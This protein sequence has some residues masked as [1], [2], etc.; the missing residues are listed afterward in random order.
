MNFMSEV[1]NGNSD[2]TQPKAEETQEKPKGEESAPPA[3]KTEEAK[4][5]ETVPLAALKAEREKRQAVEAKQQALEA[6]LKQLQEQGSTKQAE[7]EDDF[8]IFENP[9]AVLERQKQEM[10]LQT[11]AMVARVKHE[12]FDEKATI[13]FQEMVNQN[14]ALIDAM[15][16]DQNPAEFIYRESKKHLDMKEFSDPEAYKQKLRAEL[17]QQI[18]AEYESKSQTRIPPDLASA[19]AAGGNTTKPAW[20]GPRPMKDIL[21]KRN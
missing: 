19:P 13:F 5:P 10:L 17:E 4:P 7:P 9:K 16:R 21:T 2:V 14:P 3:P 20:S 1:I 11:S 8:A 15:L 12:D 18:R 6:Q